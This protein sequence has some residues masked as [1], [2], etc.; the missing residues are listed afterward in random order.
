MICLFTKNE[1]EN[2]ANKIDNKSKGSKHTIF[3]LIQ[4]LDY[5]Y[6]SKSYYICSLKISSEH[7]QALK[8]LGISHHICFNASILRSCDSHDTRCVR[9]ALLEFLCLILTAYYYSFV[10]YRWKL[11]SPVAML[12][13]P[14]WH[15]HVSVKFEKSLFRWIVMIK[16]ANEW[17]VLNHSKK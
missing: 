17:K 16:D 7:C 9:D 14:S 6:A 15:K 3:E 1:C 11:L 2:Y 8:I 5:H 13:C 10:I 12:L 4:N